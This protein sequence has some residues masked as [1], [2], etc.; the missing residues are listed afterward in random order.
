MASNK[1]KP[2]IA[3]DG[4]IL[5]GD[6]KDEYL[7]HGSNDS[8]FQEHGTKYVKAGHI[9]SG[10]IAVKEKFT[11]EVREAVRLS[12][13]NRK[14]LDKLESKAKQNQHQKEHKRLRVFLQQKEE[15]NQSLVTAASSSS[16]DNQVENSVTE[17][18]KVGMHSCTNTTEAAIHAD[19]LLGEAS[20]SSNHRESEQ[21]TSSIDANL[22]EKSDMLGKYRQAAEERQRNIV[23]EHKDELDP[24]VDFQAK[25][26][27]LEKI[28]NEYRQRQKE[29]HLASK[30]SQK[31]LLVTL[32]TKERDV[33]VNPQTAASNGS[34]VE[35]PSATE[36]SKPFQSGTSS[37]T[38]KSLENVVKMKREHAEDVGMPVN[39]T[40]LQVS[41]SEVTQCQS[42]ALTQQ[43]EVNKDDL[44]N[45]EMSVSLQVTSE[46]SRQL[47][48]NQSEYMQ[49]HSEGEKDQIAYETNGTYQLPKVDADFQENAEEFESKENTQINYAE[50]D[51]LVTENKQLEDQELNEQVKYEIIKIDQC[52]QTDFPEE[53]GE[54][55]LPAVGKKQWHDSEI[56]Y[57][58]E[59]DAC[60]MDHKAEKLFEE[61]GE[62]VNEDK[63]TEKQELNEQLDHEI[64]KK[65][66]SSHTDGSIPEENGKLNVE[67]NYLQDSKPIMKLE[68]EVSI[69]DQNSQSDAYSQGSEESL[70]ED[71]KWEENEQY[72]FEYETSESDD[73]SQTDNFPGEENGYPL[74]AEDR[75]WLDS[76]P[77][78]QR[79][80]EVNTIDQSPEI[81][82]YSQSSGNES[83]Q[84]EGEELNEQTD[85]ETSLENAF[86][87]A[88]TEEDLHSEDKQRQ[89]SME[90]TDG[91]VDQ[92]LQNDDNRQSNFEEINE[93]ESDSK[94]EQ[95][96]TDYKSLQTDSTSTEEL[97]K[98]SL[99]ECINEVQALIEHINKQSKPDQSSQKA[100]SPQANPEENCE[101]ESDNKQEQSETDQS[102]QT[103]QANS[104]ENCEPDSDYKQEQSKTDQ[105]SQQSDNSPEESCE[106][107]SDNK[108]EQ[109]ETNQSS[110]KDSISTEEPTKKSLDENQTD[111]SSQK[112]DSPLANSEPNSDTKQEWSEIDQSSQ[113]NDNPWPQANPEEN[114]EL[115]SNSIQ[116]QG[117]IDQSLQT[118][119]MSIGK[120]AEKSLDEY[121]SEIQTLIEHLNS[122]KQSKPNK[123]LQKD[124][125]PPAK[126]EENDEPKSKNKNKQSK[127]DQSLPTKTISTEKPVEKSSDGE[128]TSSE[129]ILD[130]MKHLKQA[131]LNLD[132]DVSKTSTVLKSA[133]RTATKIRKALPSKV[134]NSPIGKGLE[135][136]KNVAQVGKDAI[137]MVSSVTKLAKETLTEINSE[138]NGSVQSGFQA[139]AHASATPLQATSSGVKVG[140]VQAKVEGSFNAST[141]LGST[142]VK[143][144]AKL[145]ASAECT[146]IDV[147]LGDD[148]DNNENKDSHKHLS[149]DKA[150]MKEYR[151]SFKGRAAVSAK[152]VSIKVN[153][154]NK[155]KLPASDKEPAV[156][157]DVAADASAKGVDVQVGNK[158]STG[159]STD[160]MTLDAHA[161]A[162]AT[163]CEVLLGNRIKNPKFKGASATAKAKATG[164]AVKAGNYCKSEGKKSLSASAE[165]NITG[166]ELNVV[167]ISVDKGGGIGVKAVAELKASVTAGNV[168][169]GVGGQTGIH[170]STGVQVG[171]IGI[172]LGPPSLNIAP[173]SIFNFGFGGGSSNTSTKGESN[174]NGGDGDTGGNDEN[175]G[176]NSANPGVGISNSGNANSCASQDYSNAMNTTCSLESALPEQLMN[177]SD[178][179][180]GSSNGNVNNS[181]TQFLKNR[182]NITSDIDDGE[183]EEDNCNDHDA[184]PGASVSN[185]SSQ[186]CSNTT[187]PSGGYIE[188]KNGNSSGSISGPSADYSQEFQNFSSSLSATNSI[189]SDDLEVPRRGAVLQQQSN[190]NTGNHLVNQN[191]SIA[192]TSAV[193]NKNASTNTSDHSYSNS[194]VVHGSN[195][196]HQNADC[197]NH[198]PCMADSHGSSTNESTSGNLTSDNQPCNISTNSGKKA[199]HFSISFDQELAA[200]Q[201]SHNQPHSSGNDR[202][203]IAGKQHA[204][205]AGEAVTHDV[206]ASKHYHKHTKVKSTTMQNSS[207][208]YSHST[209]SAGAS[210]VDSKQHHHSA[211]RKS[212]HTKMKEIQTQTA[213]H[214]QLHSSD[215]DGHVTAA[216]GDEKHSHDLAGE[217]VPQTVNARK[218][219]YKH[220]KMKK[221]LRQ[222]S[223]QN[224]Q[225]SSN[226]SHVGASILSKK[227]LSSG[228][229]VTATVSDKQHNCDQTNAAIQVVST[230]KTHHTS[231][232]EGICTQA[233]SQT[234]S[235]Q[236]SRV[237]AADAAADA[238][239]TTSKG[240]QH[241]YDPSKVVTKDVSGRDCT[242]RKETLTQTTSSGNSSHI[243]AVPVVPTAVSGRQHS[244]DQTVAGKDLSVSKKHH[245][246]VEMKE[247]QT[248]TTS[249]YS[250]GK[251]SQFVNA[252]TISGK[253]CHDQ[254]VAGKTVMQGESHRK[255][256]KVKRVP[257]QSVSSSRGVAT[258]SA[259]TV[260]AKQH[261]QVVVSKN[262]H[263]NLPSGSKDSHGND[264]SNH[265]NHDQTTASSVTPQVVSISK[266]HHACTN[267]K[268]TTS[269]TSSGK[270]SH[271][272]AAVFT[273]KDKQHSY[274]PSKVVTKDL[275]GSENYY[276]C[277][278]VKDTHL[279][280]TSSGH[281]AAAPVAPSGRQHGHDM[282]VAGKVV[283][284]DLSVCKKHRKLAEVKEIQTVSQ[285]ELYSSAEDINSTINSKQCH[286]GQTV[287]SKAGT[288]NIRASEKLQKHTK[289]NELDTQTVKQIPGGKDSHV[290]TVASTATV[291][292]NEHNQTV[293]SKMVTKNVSTTKHH[294][295]STEIK[296]FQTQTTSQNL[297]SSSKDSHVDDTVSG[298][299]D[300]NVAGKV[301]TQAVDTSESQHTSIKVKEIQAQ[302]TLQSSSGND[303]A[304]STTIVSGKQHSPNQTVNSKAVTQDV[305]ASKDHYKHTDIK[306]IQPQRASQSKQ[307]SSGKDGHDTAAVS[308]QYNHDHVMG[309]KAAMQAVDIS[310][311]HL[312]HREIKEENI[313]QPRAS[314]LKTT[315]R[316]QVEFSDKDNDDT[317]TTVHGKT[318][319][320]DQ[321]LCDKATMQ[322]ETTARHRHIPRK[323]NE[324]Y[325]QPGINKFQAA[326]GV[327]CDG[328]GGGNDFSA[329]VCSKMHTED[330]VDYQEK[331]GNS[332]SDHDMLDEDI[333]KVLSLV[334]KQQKTT[335]EGGTSYQKPNMHELTENFRRVKDQLDEEAA[336]NDS[337]NSRK[338]DAVKRPKD[339]KTLSSSH[340]SYTSKPDGDDDIE[341]VPI[342]DE[343]KKPIGSNKNIF[344][345]DSI[346]SSTYKVQESKKP[347]R[348]IG[349]HVVGFK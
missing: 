155:K 60:I 67:D 233:M 202:H 94:H 242:K 347:L 337:S 170:F 46:V 184:A 292:A 216:I 290:T 300:Q 146:G 245:K 257:T 43:N 187:Y 158:I 297:P 123:H 198:L 37:S 304:S 31:K 162:E 2:Y 203:V 79:E 296:E 105:S 58:S 99:D 121:I 252:A 106:P 28:R 111:Q 232:V 175:F 176:G 346:R 278:E 200:M 274:D 84:W 93:L 283:P 339:S 320:S 32:Y 197:I 156:N 305:T 66:E 62:T 280:T 119:T 266:N 308:K 231:S 87:S 214:T 124:A 206:G 130:S 160:N 348:K 117:E 109:S 239:A 38:N 165:A 243:V 302:T 26:E 47:E 226:G 36:T 161:H 42:K 286:H 330:A 228:N 151:A 16:C 343:K 142:K 174:G 23:K 137:D 90:Q 246:H 268:E 244:H 205:V 192:G 204:H 164:A 276:T 349:R 49:E 150:K 207:T 30:T 306:E 210:V 196:A 340:G 265:H 173:F 238:A 101:L 104:E 89:N 178:T 132:E 299:H 273:T 116:E 73:S 159:S 110:Q 4:Q 318:H 185:W 183:M 72:G 5:Y 152:G 269:Q 331:G 259:A 65:D 50:N 112:A 134:K 6:E 310:K 263:Q 289:V 98:K 237:A 293:A 334:S 342:P 201:I 143:I 219:H 11:D 279:K 133:E 168:H 40:L 254:I 22:K 307:Q 76:E 154:T 264:S 258:A 107:D 253:Q 199:K 157:V 267:I 301:V 41:K 25:N 311:S 261:D 272:A 177:G 215:E 212:H 327:Q 169:V 181:S 166:K 82:A 139:S 180:M 229:T 208:I 15:G 251:D 186:N 179:C 102:S 135:M 69:L 271:L 247:I 95:N 70:S 39:A 54:L 291:S 344:T 329:P 182:S 92:W 7:R 225:P 288:Q 34:E 138:V 163:G 341:E 126:P 221:S 20:S 19:K 326:S 285:H 230:S 131:V 120:P 227:L 284:K 10:S 222:R 148:K 295:H 52:T 97:I 338:P 77:I 333:F 61:N 191:S 51:G 118:D 153:T 18:H 100:D 108:Q 140:H 209:A 287:A 224:Q 321:L 277:T 322:T 171:N 1:K 45:L 325:S 312:K 55:E 21:D 80:R 211:S 29:E 190:T 91:E 149:T 125:I 68:S 218:P 188:G 316:N 315:S 319:S 328:S 56:P 195:E 115:E 270:G 220:K 27:Q 128:C 53:D 298:I 75:H 17:D 14:W 275:S 317:S 59:H 223:S 13:L 78:E 83:D 145:S 24:A 241:S 136:I 48:E 345:M 314:V 71:K 3:K 33:D 8:E 12:G 129:Q 127:T 144:D 213:L 35:N 249:L 236:D 303:A 313:I 250:S 172:N 235:R 324:D 281:I 86:S 194:N 262:H 248:Q 141:E 88:N 114:C 323:L 147:T 217:A 9:L 167:N 113:K 189:S 282:T 85:Y 332:A 74:N 64:G 335:T 193:G 294:C 122:H 309:G 44:L 63:Q 234:S 256:T 336:V 103:P 81:Y 240:K 96:E 57:Q 255:H 260:S